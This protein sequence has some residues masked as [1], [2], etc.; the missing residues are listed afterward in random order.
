MKDSNRSRRRWHK[1]PGI[2]VVVL[3]LLLGSGQAAQAERPLPP[4]IKTDITVSW[5]IA[6]LTEGITELDLAQLLA[7]D[8]VSITHVSYEG[9]AEAAGRF[10]NHSGS[11]GFAEG[12]VLSTGLAHHVVGPNQ[13]ETTSSQNHVAGDPDLSL[14]AGHPTYDA[15]SIVFDFVPDAAHITFRYV[16]ASE[17]YNEYANTEFNDVFAFY[18]NDA[19]CATVDG[20]PVSVNSINA[21]N[22]NPGEDP[23][24]HYANLFR[25]NDLDS[26]SALDIE[27]DGLTVVLTCEAGVTPF[28]VNHLRLVIADASD[29]VVDSAIFLRAGSLTTAP[30]SVTLSRFDGD[31]QPDWGW[32]ALTAIVLLALLYLARWRA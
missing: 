20:Q 1:L 16:F 5:L 9:A 30:T 12:I 27:L 22:P 21:G 6:D 18:I 4:A 24:P 15:A 10:A 17:E 14:L 3:W 25:N 13:S 7:G 11:V 32:L 29:D 2:L 23:T 31:A 8:G 19:N 26:G 28:A